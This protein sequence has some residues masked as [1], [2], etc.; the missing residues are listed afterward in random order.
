[1]E[2]DYFRRDNNMMLL[3]HCVTIRNLIITGRYYLNAGQVPC[4]PRAIRYPAPW[5]PLYREKLQKQAFR[6]RK[7]L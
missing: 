5:K 4:L 1:M 3:F 6:E 7:F 2:G